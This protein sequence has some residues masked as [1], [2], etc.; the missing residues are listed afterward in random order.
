MAKRF[1]WLGG[2][3]LAGAT[4]S[5]WVQRK[6]K[7]AAQKMLPNAIRNEVTARVASGRE[8]AAEVATQSTVARR[9]RRAWHQ[10]HPT[11][12]DLTAPTAD[13]P[14]LKLVDDT[15]RTA[16]PDSTRPTLRERARR[17]RR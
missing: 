14:S 7:R 4:S 17:A 9:A 13:V 1:F 6:V 8:R 10:I 15:D 5:W 2:G 11:D 3:Y 12:I 16:R